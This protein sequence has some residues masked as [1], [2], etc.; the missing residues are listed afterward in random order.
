MKVNNMETKRRFDMN[1]LRRIL[2][3]MK[4]TDG[5]VFKT[6]IYLL[7]VGIGFVFLFPILYMFSYSI[8][9]LPDLLNPMVSWIPTK[10]YFKNYRTAYVVLDFFR[11]LLTSLQVT[12]VPAIFQTI[13]AAIVGYGFAKF[14]FPLKSLLLVLILSTFIIPPQ[15][16]MIPR[17]VMFNQYRLLGKAAAIVIPSIFGQ[18]VNA[19]I[20][21]LIFYMFFLMIPKSLDEAAEIDGAN[22]YYIFYK[23]ALPL[24]TPAII[25]SF[26]FSFVWYWNETYI[27]SL[28]LRG[29]VATLQFKLFNFIAEYQAIIKNPELNMV[30]EGIKMAG[31]IYIII[32]VLIVYFILQRWFIE[33]ID[34]SGITGE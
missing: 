4:W 13:M 23:I 11:T 34:R 26:L 27:S 14:K 2:L 30:N 10:L 19:A 24:V 7:L 17:Y 33:G 21:I 25:T 18:G 3:G 22:R 8:K 32:P 28:V 20:F 16:I 15:V 6:F 1:K 31:M 12:L 5:L 9:D 29:Q